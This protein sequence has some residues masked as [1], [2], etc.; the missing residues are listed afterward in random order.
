MAQK[1]VTYNYQ[2]PKTYYFYYKSTEKIDIIKGHAILC[3][4]CFRKTAARKNSSYHTQ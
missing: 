3:C 2:Y 1:K 4:M